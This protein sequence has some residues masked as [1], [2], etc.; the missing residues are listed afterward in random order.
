MTV[1]APP[2]IVEAPAQ[3]ERVL[4]SLFD[5]FP[6]TPGPG[7]WD[8]GGITF[9]PPGG[10]GTASRWTSCSGAVKP[11]SAPTAIPIFRPFQVIGSY[12]CSTLGAPEDPGRYARQAETNLAVH[13]SQQTENELWTGTLALANGLETPFLA[14]GGATTVATGLPYENALARLLAALRGCMG[15]RR[16]VIHMSPYMAAIFVRANALHRDRQT[17]KLESAFGDMVVAGAGY[18]GGGDVAN[19]VYSILATGA[20][21]GTFTLTVTNPQTQV[22]ETTAGIAFN[23]SA[24]AVKSALVA[25]TFI[26][27]AD[28]TT[29]GGALPGT[30]VL[31]TF[32]GDLAG[33]P[34]EMTADRTGLTGGP[35]TILTATTAGGSAQDSTYAATWM[36]ATGPLVTHQSDI[37]VI[38]EQVRDVDLRTNTVTVFAERTV[39][40]GFSPCCHLAVQADLTVSGD[41]S[42][43]VVDGEGP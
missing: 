24:A 35:G 28:V 34:I 42:D 33:L 32:T 12:Q 2:E 18:T 8:A 22:D 19:A 17:G 13:F 39:V 20:F 14:D 38:P 6:P 9:D 27:S 7:H 31:V 43:I 21:A 15:N 29:S 5:V 37:T 23:A 3:E 1:L 4:G 41:D 16:G 26:D 11:T 25:L 10:C 36:Y 30:A 40:Y